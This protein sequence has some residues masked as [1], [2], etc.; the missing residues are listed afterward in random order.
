[1]VFTMRAWQKLHKG[2]YHAVSKKWKAIIIGVIFSFSLTLPIVTHANLAVR[3]AETILEE[4]LYLLNATFNYTLTQEVIEALENGVTLKFVLEINVE[5]E[6]WY[7]WDETVAELKQAY[8]IKYFSLSNKYVLT[9]LNTGIQ[10]NYPSLNTLLTTL[11]RLKNFPLLDEPLVENQKEYW[12]RLR[13]YLDI[14]ALPAPLRPV[15]YLSS[16]WRLASDWYLCP[17]KP[18]Q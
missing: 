6:R 14:E 18:V 4:E 12:V 2:I 15:A 13:F 8:Q 17:L 16:E 10:E 5:R 1:M 3:Y 9:Y 11:S 7:M